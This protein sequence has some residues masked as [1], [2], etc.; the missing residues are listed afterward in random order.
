MHRPKCKPWATIGKVV[1]QYV[2]PGKGTRRF[3]QPYAKIEENKHNLRWF[4]LF[5]RPRTAINTGNHKVTLVVVCHNIYSTR[6]FHQTVS[7]PRRIHIVPSNTVTCKI[8]LNITLPFTEQSVLRQVHSLF[9]SEI[10]TECNTVLPL[11]SSGIV[12]LS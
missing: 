11:S 8:H 2:I 10:S 12:T 3:A 5:E 6:A 9:Q 4:I 1:N 7:R